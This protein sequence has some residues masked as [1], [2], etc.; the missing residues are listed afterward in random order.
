MWPSM[1]VYPFPVIFGI[2]G[3]VDT[4]ES[5][6]GLDETFEGALLFLIEDVA[7]GEQEDDHIVVREPLVVH[8]AI[9]VVA[10]KNLKIVQ[11]RQLL[12]CDHAGRSGIVMPTDGAGDEQRLELGGAG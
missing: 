3:T 8:H 11:F 5:L 4:N 6:A 7:G 10:P 9:G 1:S 12:K 2:G